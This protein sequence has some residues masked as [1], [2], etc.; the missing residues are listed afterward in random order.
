[1]L[2]HWLFVIIGAMENEKSIQFLPFNAI[3]E[4]ML[5][6][7]RLEV[8]QYVF[9][10]VNQLPSGLQRGIHQTQKK[11][12]KISGFRNS[13]LAPVPL[14]V[15]NSVSAFEKSS[16]FVAEILSAWKALHEDLGE[17]VGQVLGEIGWE[18]L[19]VEANRA[20]LPGFMT[21]WPKTDTYE[22]IEARFGEM[23]PEHGYAENDVRLMVVWIGG[24]LPYELYT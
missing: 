19:P 8:I 22:V 5:P 12:L 6:E 1:M 7:Y 23:F 20:K 13:T 9:Q 16:E 21:T 3:N 18:I 15:R 2:K 4:F 10:N 11:Y 17:K 14:K 24:R